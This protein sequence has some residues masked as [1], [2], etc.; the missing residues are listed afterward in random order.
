MQPSQRHGARPL[1]VGYARI[2]SRNQIKSYRCSYVP[3]STKILLYSVHINYISISCRR[4]QTYKY[5]QVKNSAIM[6][7]IIQFLY[8]F[9]DISIT[10]LTK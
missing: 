10:Q 7:L 2:S 5:N 6:A 1:S 4:G 8:E 3:S 9:G